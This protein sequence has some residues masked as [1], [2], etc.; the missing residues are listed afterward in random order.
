[1]FKAAKHKTVQ[2]EWCGV[3]QGSIFARWPPAGFFSSRIL[4]PGSGHDRRTV[5]VMRWILQSH[6]FLKI[7]APSF[8][9]R[10]KKALAI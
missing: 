8:R 1:M 6:M 2:E 4:G 3:A 7:H 9:G 5:Q 10:L